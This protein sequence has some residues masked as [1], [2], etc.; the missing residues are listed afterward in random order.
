MLTLDF[1]QTRNDKPEQHWILKDGVT[2]IQLADTT[3]C[4]DAGAKGENL[5]LIR[6]PSLETLETKH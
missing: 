2:K 5:S 3:L 4:M 6:A 1:S